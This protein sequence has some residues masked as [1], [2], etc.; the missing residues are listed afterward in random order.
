M[1]Q[2]KAVREERLGFLEEAAY[3]L[4]ERVYLTVE[5]RL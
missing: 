3:V 2:D 5:T 4:S 1:P